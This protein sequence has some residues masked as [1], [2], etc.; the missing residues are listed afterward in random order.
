[1]TDLDTTLTDMASV[2]GPCF[3]FMW[4]LQYVV[5]QLADL[6]PLVKRIVIAF[7]ATL[8]GVLAVVAVFFLPIFFSV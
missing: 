5:L 2:W 4:A 3:L 1:M 6:E 8:V 7:F